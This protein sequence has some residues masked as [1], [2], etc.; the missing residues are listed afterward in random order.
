MDERYEKLA[1]LVFSVADCAESL[2]SD[3]VR[4]GNAVVVWS[5]LEHLKRIVDKAYALA[6]ELANVEGSGK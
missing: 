6:L 2:D 4:E 5:D 1:S 3:D